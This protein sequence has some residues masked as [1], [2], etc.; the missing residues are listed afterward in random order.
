MSVKVHHLNCGSMCPGCQRLIS[1]RGSWTVPG[2]LV[3]HCL[4]IETNESL[5]LVDTGLGLADIHDPVRRLGRGFLSLLRP[6]L[7]IEEA[8][9]SQV[10]GLGYDPRD[11]RHIV[12][13]HLD[14][15]H[16]GGLS[17]FPWADVHVFG[18]E[19]RAATNPSLR[20]RQR[21]RP[22]QFS[23]QPRWVEHQVQGD[24]WLGFESI[25]AIPGL[26]A[27]VLIVP[28]VGHTRGHSGV[29]VQEN[30]K[31]LLHCGDAYFHRSQ[32]DRPDEM[33]V[34]LRVFEAMVQ[35]RRKPRLENQ[36]RLLELAHQ[37]REQVELFC[38]HD[39]EEF[40]RYRHG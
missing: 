36:R 10:R 11:V 27:D 15:D 35:T 8:A 13:T 34:G 3:S 28:L 5:I 14:L 31:W 39:P 26:S 22:L 33:P 1:G 37:R 19:L 40:A 24:Q 38:A 2:E 16:A 30:G 6:R 29:A 17:D 25:Q 32:V 21:Y 9:I 4:L 23:H 20:D 7:S 18:P 12:P